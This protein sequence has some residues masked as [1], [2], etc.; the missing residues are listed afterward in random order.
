MIIRSL[1]VSSHDQVDHGQQATPRQKFWQS[2]Y[3]Y[4]IPN[5]REP[6]LKS[7]CHF[8]CDLA[9]LLRQLWTD[10]FSI[11]ATSAVCISIYNFRNL[12][13]DEGFASLIHLLS[14]QIYQSHTTLLMQCSRVSLK[15]KEAKLLA[16]GT[17]GGLSLLR[18]HVNPIT[19]FW[20]F[21]L[22]GVPDS[23]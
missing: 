16:L 23:S 1:F 11:V 3:D 12:T 9:R 7:S 14:L 19:L 13:L 18:I 21:R 5:S 6:P 10:V 20:S 2:L 4:Q 22:L 8:I 15:L 17:I